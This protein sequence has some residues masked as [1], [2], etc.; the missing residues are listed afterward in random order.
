MASPPKIPDCYVCL[1]SKNVLWAHLPENPRIL[2][3]FNPRDVLHLNPDR[4][5]FHAKLHGICGICIQQLRKQECGECRRTWNMSNIQDI[6]IHLRAIPDSDLDNPSAHQDFM[7]K[8]DQKPPETTPPPGAA[9]AAKTLPTPPP[10]AAPIP[11]RRDERP[12][13]RRDAQPQPM[14]IDVRLEQRPIQRPQTT[15]AVKIAQCTMMLVCAATI[16]A[17]LFV[18][19]IMIKNSA[20]GHYLQHSLSPTL[21]HRQVVVLAGLSQ[22]A[23]HVQSGLASCVERIQRCSTPVKAAVVLGTIYCIDRLAACLRR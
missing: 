9:P 17:G 14:R 8:E 3:A 6:L 1:E 20:I 16:I 4:A 5:A 10:P 15:L 22:C 2:G 12:P 21:A 19:C 18:V 23:N 7:I 13:I 11:Q